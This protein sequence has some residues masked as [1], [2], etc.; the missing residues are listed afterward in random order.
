MEKQTGVQCTIICLFYYYYMLWFHVIAIIFY[1]Q[2]RQL[3]S[4]GTPYLPL[5]ILLAGASLVCWTSNQAL[6]DVG[7]ATCFKTTK[8]TGFV[9]LDVSSFV[10]KLLSQ[11][12]CLTKGVHM[13]CS[14]SEYLVMQNKFISSVQKIQYNWLFMNSG[15]DSNPHMSTLQL[16]PSY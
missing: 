4:F 12:P 11:C 5:C 9:R 1:L 2:R 15:P 10:N 8:H 14:R 6:S 3:L 13:A 16:R 7:T